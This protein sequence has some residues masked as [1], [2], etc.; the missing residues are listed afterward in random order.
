MPASQVVAV[1][2][3]AGSRAIFEKG[4]I[5]AKAGSGA[6]ALW[7]RVLGEYL[8][9]RGTDGSLGFPTS[10]VRPDGSGGSLA[11]FEHGTIVCPKGRAC[12]VE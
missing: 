1:N 12:R 3:G 4:R 9:R 6:H 7:G 10:R 2:P 5:L 8:D 11:R